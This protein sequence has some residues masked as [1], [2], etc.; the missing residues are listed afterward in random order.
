MKYFHKILDAGR[1]IRL[2][3]RIQRHLC[4]WETRRLVCGLSLYGHARSNQI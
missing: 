3:G 4:F 1:T 2:P